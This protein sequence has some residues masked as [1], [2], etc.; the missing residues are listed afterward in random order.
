MAN[1]FVAG[2]RLTAAD[3]NDILLSARLPSN[4]TRTSSTTLQDASGLA[5]PLLA[6]ATYAIDGWL[7]YSASPSGGLKL[8]WTIPSGATGFWSILGPL[9]GSAPIAGGERKNYTDYGAISFSAAV[10]TLAITGDDEFPT[11]VFPSCVPRGT[12]TTAGTAGNLQLR[13]AQVTSSGTS[14]VLQAN[15]WLRISRLD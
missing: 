13:M 12:I 11:T 10:P 7:F 8:G 6:N 3:L 4:V 9:Y 15:S 2:Q 14:T 1:I 5:V